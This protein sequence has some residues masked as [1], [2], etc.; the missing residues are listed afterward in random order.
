MYQHQEPVDPQDDG[1]GVFPE[2]WNRDIPQVIMAP[3]AGAEMGS[4]DD[5]CILG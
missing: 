1:Q 3:A 2:K 4:P 5:S